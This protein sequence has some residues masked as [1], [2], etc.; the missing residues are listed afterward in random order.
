M[1][2]SKTAQRWREVHED[3]FLPKHYVLIIKR[4]LQTILHSVA[5]GKA[6]FCICLIGTTALYTRSSAILK[7]IQ[8]PWNHQKS[9]P[10]SHI[11]GLQAPFMQIA[12]RWQSS[13]DSRPYSQGYSRF[14]F[15]WKIFPHHLSFAKMRLGSW[16][17]LPESSGHDVMQC[18]WQ[19]AT[20]QGNL[21]TQTTCKY[22]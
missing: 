4:T 20:V 2:N 21:R 19:R 17:G 10:S 9:S 1:P 16:P 8:I 5:I 15:G 22:F 3:I 7:T 11:A 18:C 14:A 13:N 12:I 6:R